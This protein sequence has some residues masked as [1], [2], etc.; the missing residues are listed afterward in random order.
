MNYPSGPISLILVL[1]AYIFTSG[2]ALPQQPANQQPEQTFELGP[3]I[4][5]NFPDPCI[6]YDKGVW[7]AFATSTTSPANATRNPNVTTNIQI[8]QSNDFIHWDIVRT[9]GGMEKDALPNTP[10]WVNMSVPQTWAPDLNQLDD[11]M[12]HQGPRN[13]Y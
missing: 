9:R 2:W 13:L 8:A 1:C 10:P 4:T 5:S 11:G 3:V 12:W 7:Y 6:A